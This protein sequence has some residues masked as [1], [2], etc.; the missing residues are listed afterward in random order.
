MPDRRPGV[1]E[2]RLDQQDTPVFQAKFDT[3]AW[4][5]DLLA[6]TIAFDGTIEQHPELERRTQDAG[7]GEPGRS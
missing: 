1:R 6:F 7:P 5:G 4:S 2:Q 3:S